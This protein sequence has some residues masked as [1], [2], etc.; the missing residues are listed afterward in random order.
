MSCCRVLCG[1][2]LRLCF[3]RCDFFSQKK[4]AGLVLAAAAR[5][6]QVVQLCPISSKAGEAADSMCSSLS[7]KLQPSFLVTMP[8]CCSM[9]PSFYAP[10]AW[11]SIPLF[12]CSSQLC[13][14]GSTWSSCSHHHPLRLAQ[15]LVPCAQ[16]LVEQPYIPASFSVIPFFVPCMLGPKQ[17]YI[18]SCA[19]HRLFCA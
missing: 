2:A 19:P 4:A 18:L 12:C 10:R 13:T 11:W 16:G 9:Q 8:H 5:R 6:L 7:S 1:P 3:V 17:P 15:T 14:S